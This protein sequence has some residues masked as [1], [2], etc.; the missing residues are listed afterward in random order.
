[1][2]AIPLSALLFGAVL[3]AAAPALSQ[4]FCADPAAF[5]TEKMPPSCLETIGAGAAALD[6][7]A[8][9]ED[10]AAAA[11]AYSLCLSRAAR[12]CGAAPSPSDHPAITVMGGAGCVRTG[13]GVPGFDPCAS[14]ATKPQL[15]LYA[16]QK[17]V[18]FPDPK[19]EIWSISGAP[20]RL[21]DASAQ[22]EADARE[23]AT[24][25]LETPYDGVYAIC[26]RYMLEDREPWA[27]VRGFKFRKGATTPGPGFAFTIYEGGEV[28]KPR[29]VRGAEIDCAREVAAF[30]Q[31]G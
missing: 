2:R 21:Q 22:I 14:A 20:E 24:L 13:G 7:G 4:D 15:I 1:M 11:E 17:G 10:C 26:A 25:T 9:P 18:S 5:C 12:D 28:R 30:L 31:G 6:R 19:A 29:F 8:A 3:L 16:Q 23:S 27:M